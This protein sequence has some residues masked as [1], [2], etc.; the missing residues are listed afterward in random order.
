MCIYIHTLIY[1]WVYKSQ[2]IKKNSKSL[3]SS[4]EK[5]CWNPTNLDFRTLTFWRTILFPST[6]SET[7][8][9]KHHLPTIHFL[10]HLLLV[11]GRSFLFRNIAICSLWHVYDSTKSHLKKMSDV[12]PKEMKKIKGPKA[13]VWHPTGRPGM[14]APNSLALGRISPLSGLARLLSS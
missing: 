12:H 11:S 8:K 5:L 13:F 6:P 14:T 7:H 3:T 1:M 2:N 10:V 9:R 4:R